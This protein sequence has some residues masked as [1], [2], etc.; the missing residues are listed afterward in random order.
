MVLA[1]DR[2]ASSFALLHCG[3]ITP[4]NLF[5]VSAGLESTLLALV[6]VDSRA[7]L[8]QHTQT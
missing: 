1:G 5:K 4:S 3:F 7:V 6:R 2:A 8:L